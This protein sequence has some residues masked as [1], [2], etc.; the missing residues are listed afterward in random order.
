VAGL[1]PVG[2]GADGPERILHKGMRCRGL[3][4]GE[5]RD[6]DAYVMLDWAGRM[7]NQLL[8]I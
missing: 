4:L 5:K 7:A 2:I 1:G 6:G 3:G 8:P